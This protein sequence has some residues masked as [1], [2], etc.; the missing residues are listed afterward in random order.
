MLYCYEVEDQN[1]WQYFEDVC[2]ICSVKPEIKFLT[3]ILSRVTPT[4]E[5]LGSVTNGPFIPIVLPQF[6]CQNLE[7]TPLISTIA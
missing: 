5:V 2:E 7:G 6:D 3:E 4:G 1:L